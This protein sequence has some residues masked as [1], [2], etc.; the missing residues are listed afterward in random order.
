MRKFLGVRA[1]AVV[2]WAVAAMLLSAQG[3]QAAP[4]VGPPE[5]EPGTV[6][7]SNEEYDAMMAQRCPEEGWGR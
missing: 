4:P 1:G 7:M 5:D 6:V 2:G 3:A